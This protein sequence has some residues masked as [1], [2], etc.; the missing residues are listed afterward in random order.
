MEAKDVEKICRRYFEEQRADILQNL[1][2][3]AR[4]DREINYFVDKIM[5]VFQE[6]LEKNTN[7]NLENCKN[8]IRS[9]IDEYCKKQENGIV[10]LEEYLNNRVKQ[11]T[12]KE[13]YDIITSH[14]MKNLEKDLKNQYSAEIDGI[15][16]ILILYFIF[17]I[18][19]L[20]AYI[21]P[22]I[23]Q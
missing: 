4:Y 16:A 8:R 10:L 13:P 23:N 9:Y 1:R 19:M 21:R 2:T 15:K 17:I 20:F 11:I 6:E 22:S 5:D 12:N 18:G 7:K 3:F 14:Y